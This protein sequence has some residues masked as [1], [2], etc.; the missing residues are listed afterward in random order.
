MARS[1]RE[2]AKAPDKETKPEPTPAAPAPAPATRRGGG[3]LRVSL[4]LIVATIALVLLAQQTLRLLPDW[5]NPFDEKPKDRSG[6][7]LLQSIRDLSRYEAASGN[8]Q[9][10]VDLEKDAKFL[11]SAVRGSRTLFV[12][13]GTVDA[14]VDFGKIADGAITVN[15]DRTAVTVRLPK[16]QLEPTNLDTQKSY[17]FSAQRGLINRFGDFFGNNPNNQQQ[18]YVLAAQKI[19]TAANESGLPAR[20]DQNTKQMMEQLLK[21]LGFKTVKVEP[22][23]Q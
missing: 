7:V 3:G 13:H 19:Q 4:L 15:A 8:F 2:T 18:L 22:A 16:A 23:T 20:A 5:I 1:E 21:S 6:P 12:G 11:P 10:I 9:V 14:Y 17:V